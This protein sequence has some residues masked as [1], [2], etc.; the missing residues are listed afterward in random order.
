MHPSFQMSLWQPVG[1]TTS[2]ELCSN[3]NP[4]EYRCILLAS[5][6]WTL[7][8]GIHLDLFQTLWCPENL[9]TGLFLTTMPMAIT[10]PS[11]NTLWSGTVCTATE[12]SLLWICTDSCTKWDH[13]L[14]I[15]SPQPIWWKL[16]N[17][18][19]LL[20]KFLC[21]QGSFCKHLLL[22]LESYGSWV[23][24]QLQAAGLLCISS[25]QN[26]RYFFCGVENMY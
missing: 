24:L 2:L 1:S 13:Q 11:S 23:A 12:Y 4:Q 18:S 8:Q 21:S 22:K 10:T 14:L 9:T 15:L 26:K 6:P 7:N 17:F 25:F 19:V 16:M 3:A 5:P 20:C